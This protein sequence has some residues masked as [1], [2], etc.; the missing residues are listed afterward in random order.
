[1]RTLIRYVLLT[2]MR[3]R[4]FVALPLVMLIA[5]IISR[6]LSQTSMIEGQAMDVTFIAGTFRVILTVGVAVFV[7]FHMRNAFDTKEIDVILSR[8]I[9][10]ANLVI[11]Y[12]VG[13]SIVSALSTL[14]A[15]VLIYIAGPST[16]TGYGIWT[17]SL[18]A[19]LWIVVAIALF[20]S[21]TLRSAVISVIF[22]MTLYVLSRLMGYFLATIKARLLFD[23]Y[24][25]NEA[26]RLGIKGLSIF[27]PRL[28]MFAKSYW[29]VHGANG[30]HEILLFVGQGIVIIPLLLC[31]AIIDFYRRQF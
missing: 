5:F 15:I 18:L 19:E 24:I 7:C 8:P 2:A 26:S 17:L 1:M 11:S 20:A 23:T 6:I 4:L 30:V 14:L 3:D 16:W 28:D 12:W 21:I 22:T 9:S 31:V 13:F 10:R 29:L 27:V 25:F